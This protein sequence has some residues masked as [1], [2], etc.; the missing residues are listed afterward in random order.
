MAAA[1]TGNATRVEYKMSNIREILTHLKN[2]VIDIVSAGVTHTMERQIYHVSIDKQQQK[3]L[4][5]GNI[6]CSFFV[7]GCSHRHLHKLF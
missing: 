6:V 2:G 5:I 3:T 7:N 1:A 4:E